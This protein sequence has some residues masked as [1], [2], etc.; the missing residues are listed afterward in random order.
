MSFPLVYMRNQFRRVGLCMAAL[1]A[2][3]GCGPRF[4]DKPPAP[5]GPVEVRIAP[6]AGRQ[7]KRVV[8]SVGTLFP[9][10]EAVISAEVD[11]PVQKVSVD[12]GDRVTQGQLMVQISDEEQRYILAQTEAQLWQALERLG[13]KDENAKVEDIRK[14]PEVRR[15]QA[16][17][18]DSEQRFR[19]VRDLAQQGVGSQQALE[20]AEARNQAM[21]AAYDVS[22]NQTGNLIREVQRAR[23]MLELQRKKLRDTSILAPFTASVKERQVTVGQFVRANTPLLTLVQIDP[24]R[25]RAEVP[26]RMAPWVKVGQVAEVFRGSF[27][28]PEVSR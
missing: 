3:V 1:T 5:S 8:D 16:D 11:G 23:A 22:L 24:I 9:F 28:Q 15:A 2:T 4:A 19:R 21:Q 14:T 17:L 6:V 12:L 13:L 27:C 25:L 7:V 10:D 20:E 18:I 26:E